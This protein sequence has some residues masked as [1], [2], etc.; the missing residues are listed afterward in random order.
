M[1]T[2]RH[3]FFLMPTLLITLSPTFNIYSIRL[4]YDIPVEQP[5]SMEPEQVQSSLFE[6]DA[7]F[8]DELD[9]EGNNDAGLLTQPAAMVEE[10]ESPHPTPENPQPKQKGLLSYFKQVVNRLTSPTRSSAQRPSSNDSDKH[11]HSSRGSAQSSPSVEVS[12]SWGERGDEEVEACF[13]DTSSER[14]STSAAIDGVQAQNDLTAKTNEDSAA[15]SA[16]KSSPSK[17]KVEEIA[18]I[19]RATKVPKVA[20]NE[21]FFRKDRHF[22]VA[23]DPKMSWRD[24]RL[25]MTND[26]MTYVTGNGLS[27]YFLVHPALVGIKKAQLIS[28]YKEGED[29]FASEESLVQYARD[30]LGWDGEF[31]SETVPEGRRRS[32]AEPIKVKSPPKRA[33]S[34]RES[35]P[36]KKA[37]K[38][39]NANAKMTAAHKNKQF[40]ANSVDEASLILPDNESTIQGRLLAAQ[41]TLHPGFEGNF[42]AVSSKTSQISQFMENAV[43][44]GRAGFMYVCGRPG[45]GKVGL[46]C[47]LSSSF[48][49]PP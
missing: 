25:Q 45:A 41:M 7:K 47:F 28:Q 4:K 13:A 14:S 31:E 27:S 12:A 34:K 6:I 11:S 15:P 5:A 44:T 43:L 39:P 1:R 8:S 38:S 3:A 26:G 35:P 46:H 19:S 18:D 9:H 40:T 32:R 23:I 22:S 33:G 30:K 36:T 2:L 16:T 20:S 37:R 21:T 10:T 42:C 24:M 49:F 29:Y 48:C 17:R